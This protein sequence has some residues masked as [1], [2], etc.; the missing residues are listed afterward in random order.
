MAEASNRY[1]SV[2]SVYI[3]YN[4]AGWR[5][6]AKLYLARTLSREGLING[7]QRWGRPTIRP[8]KTRRR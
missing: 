8:D 6:N 5:A 1:R 2:P 4:L 7:I 3:N